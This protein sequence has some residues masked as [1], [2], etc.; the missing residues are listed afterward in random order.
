MTNVKV[1]D[2]V[3]ANV[4]EDGGWYSVGVRPLNLSLSTFCSCDVGLK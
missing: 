2:G 1:D 4:V 3:V